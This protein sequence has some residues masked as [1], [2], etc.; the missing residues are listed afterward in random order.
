MAEP[1]PT[2]RDLEQQF[3]IQW[4][5]APDDLSLPPN[6]V[7]V[8][9]VRELPDF[10]ALVGRFFSPR[11]AASFQSLPRLQKAEAFFNLWT[12]KEAWLKATG[13]GITR[14]LNR[15]EVTFLPGEKAQLLAL[16]PE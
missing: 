15:V 14:W 4:G 5:L 10:D 2:R 7:H 11:E 1:I 9:F 6:E 13:E 16:P 12:R 8:E 3:E